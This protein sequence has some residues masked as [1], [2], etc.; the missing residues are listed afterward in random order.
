MKLFEITG[1][2]TKKDD[3]LNIS[4]SFAIRKFYVDVD[5]LRNKTMQFQVNRSDYGD[6][7]ELLDRVTE[8]DVITV[9]FDIKCNEVQNKTGGYSYFNNLIVKEIAPAYQ[10]QDEMNQENNKKDDLPF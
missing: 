8:G 10:T 4:D 6:D 3:I 9:A 7:I 2:L 1:T 5:R